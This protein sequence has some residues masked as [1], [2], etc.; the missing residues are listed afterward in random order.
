M[1]IDDQVLSEDYPH[2]NHMLQRGKSDALKVFPLSQFRRR[3]NGLMKKL[4][5][6]ADPLEKIIIMRSGCPVAVVVSASSYDEDAG[7][8]GLVRPAAA[9]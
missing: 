9:P 2:L 8:K 5:S 4:A 7:V 3:I 1:I 6:D